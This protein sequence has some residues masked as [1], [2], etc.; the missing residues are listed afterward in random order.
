VVNVRRASASSTVTVA[1]AEAMEKLCVPLSRPHDILGTVH[2]D[3]DV[4]SM[5]SIS[6]SSRQLSKGRAVSRYRLPLG[7]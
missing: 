5:R 6:Y 3:I 4:Q 2:L 7:D 1:A